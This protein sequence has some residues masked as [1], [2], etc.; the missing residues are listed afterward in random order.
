MVLF[1]ISTLATS[2]DANE[3]THRCFISEAEVYEEVTED[4]ALN[5]T[6]CQCEPLKALC[7]LGPDSIGAFVAQEVPIDFAH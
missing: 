3:L 5:C 1:V 2:I 4:Y 6:S 7:V